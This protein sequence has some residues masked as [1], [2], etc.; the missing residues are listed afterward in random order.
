MANR[1]RYVG[2]FLFLGLLAH[3]ATRGTAFHDQTANEVS[4]QDPAGLACDLAY[5][6]AAEIPGLSIQRSTGMFTNE[7]LRRRVRGCRLVIT[8][9][10]AHAPPG[11]DAANRLRDGFAAQGWQEMPSYS[12]DGKDGT[13]FAFRKTEV[14]CLFRGTWTGGAD[15][16]PSM[17]RK[18]AYR[19]SV[20]CTS[21][22]PSEERRGQS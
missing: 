2:I 8:G 21:H 5:S 10:F 22:V 4:A 1:V 13:A 20:L 16:E 11:G 14:A 15:G 7:A 18:E 19:V 17:P 6:I 9:S 3:A 12:A